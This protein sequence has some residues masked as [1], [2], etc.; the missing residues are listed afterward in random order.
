MSDQVREFTK[1][2]LYGLYQYHDQLSQNILKPIKSEQSYNLDKHDISPDLLGELTRLRD[3]LKEH[4]DQSSSISREFEMVAP[5]MKLPGDIDFPRFCQAADII[6]ET[7]MALE[8]L[9]GPSGPGDSAD[10]NLIAHVGNFFKNIPSRLKAFHLLPGERSELAEK[11]GE[12]LNQGMAQVNIYT[13]KY[14]Y[15]VDQISPTQTG[16]SPQ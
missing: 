11:L 5:K 14:G 2:F 13:K 3:D 1:Q 15:D 7:S 16:N 8:Y 10:H 4:Y 12:E 9:S 6:F